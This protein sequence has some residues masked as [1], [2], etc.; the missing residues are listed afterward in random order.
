MTVDKMDKKVSENG[1][2]TKG[3]IRKAGTGVKGSTEKPKN[4]FSR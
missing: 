4:C 1:Q 2:V 3:T